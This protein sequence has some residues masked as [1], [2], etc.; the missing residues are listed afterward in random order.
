MTE[1]LHYKT[2]TELSGLIKNR[3]ISPVEVTEAQLA[4][5][6]AL[7]GKLK[8][9]ATLMADQ[10]MVEA[11]AAEAEITAGTYRGPLHGV[12]VAVKDLCFTAGVRT[13][14]GTA[15]LAD[16]V[17]DFDS[18]VVTRFKEAGAVIL[19]KLNLT[20]GAMAGYNPKR[21]VPQNPWREDHW[22]GASSSGSG[23][24]T[25]AGLAY[26]TLGSDT[27]GSIRH[28]AAVCGTVGLKPTW[29]RVSRHGVLDLAQSLDHVGPLTRSAADAGI[30][31][32]VIS[33]LDPNDPTTL[34]EPVP[35]MINGME[36]GARGLVIGWDPR[37]GSEDLAPD[38]SNAIAASVQVMRDLGAEI[39]EVTMPKRLREYMAA[40]PTL[41]SAE[42]ADAHRLFFPERADDYG[43]WFREWLSRGSAFSAADYAAAQA[44]RHACN[45]EMAVTMANIDLLIC[46][47][48][49]RAAYP[50]SAEQAYGPIPNNR[51]PW[52]SRFTV[53]M[54]FAGLPTISVPCGLNND[55][56][57]LSLQFSGHRLSEPLL[58]RAGVAYESATS[59][60]K[61]HPPGW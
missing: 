5:I 47:S 39:V 16:H 50:Y 17:P 49:P 48:T 7:D 27:G 26:A 33:G 23:A 25:S 1:P 44:Q 61:L 18:T 54:D 43:P 12:P 15:V 4:R 56:L 36:A 57:P 11:R 30:V 9:Y 10:A 6:E 14:G 59:F 58:V 2:I 19:G 38:Y 31:M 22:P 60:H 42:A 24:A 45:G 32:Q 8:S 55:G 34:V 52:D 3:E 37:Y 28:P 46:P 21:Q 51:D 53:P 35:D 41:C 40:W 20:E 29:G 13:M